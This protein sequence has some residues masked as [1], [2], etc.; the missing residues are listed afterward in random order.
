MFSASDY[1]KLQQIMAESPEKKELLTKLLESH[2]MTISS[3]SHEIRNPLTLISS[4][5]QLISR[6]HPETASFRHWDRLLKD[7]EETRLLLEELSVYN[8]SQKLNPENTDA[9]SFF[10]TCALSFAT[11]LIRTDI[12]F[13]SQIPQDLPHLCC[14]RRKIRQV[15]LNLLKNAKD[16]VSSENISHPQITLT[17]SAA[18]SALTVSVQDNGCGISDEQLEH[19]FEPFATYKS[20]GT[21]LG[22][23]IASRIVQAHGG[24]LSVSSVPGGSTVFT[25]SLPV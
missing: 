17:I 6:E 1:D 12:E 20:D 22:L 11:S 21:G 16:A 23:P 8:N 14:D 24:S 13:V 25:F 18:G 7:V 19:I 5:L 3:I 2:Q 10:R 15:L 9:V 4:T